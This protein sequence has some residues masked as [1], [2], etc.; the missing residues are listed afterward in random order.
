M[1]Y[2]S[3]VITGDGYPVVQLH[4]SLL[5]GLCFA[6]NVMNQDVH[7]SSYHIHKSLSKTEKQFVEESVRKQ[8]IWNNKNSAGFQHVNFFIADGEGIFN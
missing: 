1:S 6:Y 4:P 8:G 7:K 5:Q 3:D 2:I